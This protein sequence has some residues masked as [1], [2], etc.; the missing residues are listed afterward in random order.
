MVVVFLQTKG[1]YSLKVF[2]TLNSHLCDS[3]VKNQTIATQ[4]SPNSPAFHVL[5]LSLHLGKNGPHMC[6][7]LLGPLLLG[8]NSYV[9]SWLTSVEALTAFCA[10]PLFPVARVRL[11]KAAS[12]MM[13]RKAR[14]TSAV[15]Q[16]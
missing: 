2:H 5:P 14:I 16:E 12:T 8:S 1:S 3:S 11:R 7:L 10:C 4:L 9:L 13:G 6:G 15:S